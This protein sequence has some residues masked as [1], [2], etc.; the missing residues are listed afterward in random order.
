MANNDASRAAAQSALDA[1]RE[2]PTLG[3]NGDETDI[4][5][6]VA[7]L[8]HL[9]DTLDVGATASTILDDAEANYYDEI[10]ED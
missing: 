7:D 5:D 2:H 8:L 3:G 6:L 1:Y 9:A 4:M 10:D